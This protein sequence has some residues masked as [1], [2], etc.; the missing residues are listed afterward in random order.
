MNRANTTPCIETT[1]F[2]LESLSASARP[3][4]SQVAA[5]AIHLGVIGILF[6]TSIVAGVVA[7]KNLNFGPLNPAPIVRVVGSEEIV[8]QGKRHPAPSASL[9]MPSDR[10]VAESQPAPGR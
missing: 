7:L 6:A 8:V 5:N 2:D 3:R 10:L 9:G 4:L 1:S